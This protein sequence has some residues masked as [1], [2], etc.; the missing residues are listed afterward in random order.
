MTDEKADTHK[1]PLTACEI[2]SERRVG[3]RGA[4]QLL[5]A[6]LAGAALGSVG[7][8][9]ARPTVARAHS[10]SDTGPDADPVG[11]GR[12]GVS[13]RDSGAGADR[14]GYG[15][16][17]G[18][19]GCTDTDAGQYADPVGNAR[20]RRNCSDSDGGRFADPAGRGRRC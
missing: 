17:R 6:T 5:G 3:R 13:D 8:G 14:V 11:G 15:R 1:K 2:V 12:T 7:V 18:R 10:D 9:L 20:C 19:T 16:G 4:L